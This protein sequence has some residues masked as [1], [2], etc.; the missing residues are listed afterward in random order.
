[1]RGLLKVPEDRRV[2]ELER[3][4]TSPVTASGRVLVRVLDRVA[5]IAGLDGGQVEVEPVPAVKPA[6]LARYGVSSKAP[7]LRELEVARADRDAA[8]HGPAVGDGVD[9]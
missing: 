2:S 7:M 5:G 8:G 6:S 4:R 9:R 3:L 1:M